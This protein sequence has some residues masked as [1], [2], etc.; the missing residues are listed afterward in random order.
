MDQS[1]TVAK[2]YDNQTVSEVPYDGPF[3][4]ITDTWSSPHMQ[5]VEQRSHRL[6]LN[7]ISLLSCDGNKEEPYYSFTYD[8]TG[9]P[10]RFN[11]GQDYFGYYN[12]KQNATKYPNQDYPDVNLT[13]PNHV[14]A[15]AGN[16]FSYG[17]DRSEDATKIKASILTEIKNAYGGKVAFEYEGHGSALEI[18][19]QGLPADNYFLG[20]TTADGLRIRTI[21]ETDPYYPANAK[22]TSFTYNGGQLFLAGGYYHAPKVMTTISPSS[23]EFGIGIWTGN[24]VTPHQMVNGSSHGYSQVT[25]VTKDNNNSL[26]SKKD[27]LFTN[28]KDATSNNLPRYT[29]TAGSKHYYEFPFTDKQYLRDWEMGLPLQI[30]DYDENGR[31]TSR[32]FNSYT[33][34]IDSTT[35][36]TKKADGT[37]ASYVKDPNKPPFPDEYLWTPKTAIPDP[38]KPFTGKALLARTVI[39]KYISDATYISDT[40]QYVYDSRSNL[41]SIVA[42]NSKGEAT[43]TKH[44]YNYDVPPNVG[45]TILSGLEKIVSTQRWKRR[46]AQQDSILLDA[47]FNRYTNQLSGS[48]PVNIWSKS[49]YSLVTGSPLT[50]AQ[51]N[52][53]GPYNT[54]AL[55]AWAVHNGN[56]ITD[57]RKATEVILYDTKGNP[58]ETRILDQ[59]Q[60]KAMIWDTLTGQKIAEASN[61]HYND[62]AFTSFEATNKGNF[63][64]ETA[65]VEAAPVPT[66]G[67]LSGQKMYAMNSFRPTVGMSG[68]NPAK[69][70]MLTFWAKDGVPSFSGPGIASLTFTAQA[71]RSGWTFYAAKFTPQTS[72]T[73]NI[74]YNGTPIYLDEIRLFPVNAAMQSMTYIPLFGQGSVTDATGRITTYSY[75]MLG[76]LA[77]VRDQEG[78]IISKTQYAVHEAE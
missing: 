2:G 5:I 34:S 10:C 74:Q 37:K 25:V 59:D 50:I 57:F 40:V 54:T 76:R 35:S 29:R 15:V 73:Y 58:L 70:Y 27:I 13:I 51:Y 20:E 19:L 39:Q 44:V 17:A 63:I 24:L 62:I 36:V 28:F 3:T 69:T 61:C 68:L 72:G 21:T 9:L 66:A 11:S 77:V 60:Y 75:D 8:A 67:P 22:I 6:R 45:G 64:Y 43:V 53:T 47:F 4:V 33:F 18:P 38:Y 55:K 52:G 16:N 41:S 32:T 1:Y 31:I 14:S 65:G 30:T 46:P 7:G 78:N 49:M 48:S 23:P 12:G 71:Q 26:L 42:Y 56:A